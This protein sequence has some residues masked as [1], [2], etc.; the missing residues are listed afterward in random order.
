MGTPQQTRSRDDQQPRGLPGGQPV[1]TIDQQPDQPGASPEVV[2]R[3]ADRAEL[4]RALEVITR[5]V[6]GPAAVQDPVHPE[7]DGAR[8]GK[9][10]RDQHGHPRVGQPHA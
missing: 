9:G 5:A 6:C 7:P 1:V 2:R 4:T 8:D 3:K 10:G